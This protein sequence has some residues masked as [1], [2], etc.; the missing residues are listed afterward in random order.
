[1]RQKKELDFLCTCAVI[2]EKIVSRV[3]K[4]LLDDASLGEMAELFKALGDPTRLKVVH[5]LLAAE[6]CVCDLGALLEMS[7]PAISHHLKL[8]RQL[9]LVTFRRSGKVV[10]Y[11]IG[12]EHIAPLVTQAIACIKKN[13][14]SDLA[15]TTA[16]MNS[17]A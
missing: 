12:D 17:S 11:S 1:M 13:G 2:H 15:R 7:P 14:Q 3:K 9:K 10:Y 5:A 6:M 8:L 4:N 16:C